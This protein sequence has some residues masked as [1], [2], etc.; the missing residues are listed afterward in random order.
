MKALALSVIA[1][2]FVIS[3]LASLGFGPALF[4]WVLKI[5]GRDVTMHFVLMGVLALSVNL[6]LAAGPW[7]GALRRVVRVTAWVTA[8][9]TLEELSQYVIPRRNFSMED[10]SA[11]LAGVV[12]GALA[13]LAFFALRRRRATA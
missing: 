7:E 10:L 5:P 4:S 11:S 2:V 1:S 9:V 3:L 8:A 13:A 12:V 6:W